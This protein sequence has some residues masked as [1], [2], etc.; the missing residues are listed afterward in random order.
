M[1]DNSI[2]E[3]IMK[4]L[5]EK[6]RGGF[7]G[8]ELGQMAFHYIK[9]QGVDKTDSNYDKLKK[10]F[11]DVGKTVKRARGGAGAS[12]ED[13]MPPKQLAKETS[14]VAHDL[15]GEKEV[16]PRFKMMTTELKGKKP[17][18]KEKLK[19][20]VELL[21]KARETKKVEK[22]VFYK[23]N[24]EQ[25]ERNREQLKRSS[26]DMFN[27]F[28]IR[29]ECNLMFE[30]YQDV[31]SGLNL[32]KI[33]D[34]DIPHIKKGLRRKADIFNQSGGY[35]S[36]TNKSLKQAYDMIF[37]SELRANPISTVL[38]YLIKLENEYLIPNEDSSD[39]GDDIPEFIRAR[40]A[41]ESLRAL[42]GREYPSLGL[43]LTY[44]KIT[45][46]IS[47]IDEYDQRL[48]HMYIRYVSLDEDSE[49]PL[50]N[51]VVY[52]YLEDT[53]GFD[54]K[55]DVNRY[56]AT[57]G[58]GRGENPILTADKKYFL[59]LVDNNMETLHKVYIKKVMPVFKKLMPHFSFKKG[60]ATSFQ[61]V[62]GNVEITQ[63]QL[64]RI[65]QTFKSMNL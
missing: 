24:P 23:T 8:Y 61:F 64:L 25:Q 12:S 46:N 58:I 10:H 31:I 33:N 4:K 5:E 52:P 18:D 57:G 38:H 63:E 39:G 21:L 13:D 42:N 14:S 11:V 16:K 34:D 9:K 59:F 51:V 2:R 53:K 41:Y 47:K 54:W 60:W 49:I 62:K 32:A 20:A 19:R 37:N 15:R 40:F 43:T 55:R 30:I 17:I 6:D 48:E 22:K 7:N 45:E 27:M 36:G 1:D 29:A 65:A 44:V 50:N 56:L 28:K 26:D 3:Y 35:L